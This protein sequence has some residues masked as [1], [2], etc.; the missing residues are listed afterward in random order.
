MKKTLG[1]LAILSMALVGCVGEQVEVPPGSVG[2][3]M[4]KDGYREGIVNTSKFRLDFC[5]QYCDQL[6]TMGVTDFPMEESMELFMPKDKLVMRFDLRLTLTPKPEQY[7]SLFSRIPPT[8][9]GAGLVIPSA[10]TYV[11]YAQQ[12]IRSEAREI[13]SEYTINEVA[14][15][16]E[17]INVQLTEALTKTIN[18]RTPYMV[19]YL[20]IADIKYPDV[21]T[22]AQIAAAERREA[23]QQEEAELEISKVQLER[24]LQETRLQRA[25]DIE[26]AQASAEVNRILGDSVT[27]AYVTYRQLDALQAIATSE[28]TKFVP[29]EMLSS[30]AAQFMVTK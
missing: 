12:I 6:V 14:S 4:G 25:I 15:S 7:E 1:M 5:I 23:I 30:M 8:T 16:R 2:K 21:I 27:P 9:T 19:R 18:E 28:N 24:L 22:N 10:M 29:V 17:A 3:I 13:L 11:T 26:I 20:G